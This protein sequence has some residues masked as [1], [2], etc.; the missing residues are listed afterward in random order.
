MVQYQDIINKQDEIIKLI[1]KISTSD[2]VE[3]IKELGEELDMNIKA[4]KALKVI[5]IVQKQEEVG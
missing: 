1:Q 2:N 3:E 5:R 4:L